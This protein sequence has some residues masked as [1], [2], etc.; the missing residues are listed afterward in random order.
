MG[1]DYQDGKNK[2]RRL[3]EEDIEL[4]IDTFNEKKDIDDFSI[5]VS[6]EEIKEKKYSLSAGQYFDIKIEY[7][8]MTPEEFE[9]KMK[10]YQKELQEYFE[11]GEKLQ[12][13]IMEQLG[14]IKYEG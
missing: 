1:E 5:S 9:T 12:K 13:E 2:K 10:E 7:I 4:I 8:D 14:K 6:Y 3:R 11:E